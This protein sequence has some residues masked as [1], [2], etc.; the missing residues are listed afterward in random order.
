MRGALNL[1]VNPFLTATGA[2]WIGKRGAGY[3]VY[4]QGAPLLENQYEAKR[5]IFHVVS[6]SGFGAGVT[7]WRYWQANNK[8]A[9]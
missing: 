2:W 7:N 9:A 1:V 5:Q 6:Y 8:A 4:D 3:R